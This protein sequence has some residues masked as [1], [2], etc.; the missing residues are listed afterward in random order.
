MEIQVDLECSGVSAEDVASRRSEAWDALS[1]IWS[2]KLDFTGWA[3]YPGKEGESEIEEVLS[4]A[5]KIR[6]TCDVFLVLGVGGSFMGAKAVIDLLG[7]RTSG[8]EVLFAGYNFSARYLREIFRKIEGKDL[9]LCVVSKSG[10]TTETLSAYGIFRE[11]MLEKYGA[12]EAAGRTYFVTEH[13][14]NYLFDLAEKEGSKVFDLAENIGGRYSVLTPVGL[15]PIA[16]S[17]IDIRNLMRGAEEIADP[18]CFKGN[19]LDYAI[20]RQKLREAGKGIEVFEFFDPYAAY[21]GEWLKQLFGESEGK[22]GKGIFP[23]SLMFSRDLHSMGQFLQQGAPEFFETFLL[24]GETGEPLRIPDSAKKPFAGKTMQQLNACAEK[25]VYD[26]HVAAGTPVIR[27]S[28]PEWN[29]ET[30][31]QLLY[32]FETECAVSA[33]LS[34]VNPFGQPGVEAYKKEMR[35]YIEKL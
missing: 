13:R 23:A 24:A 19:G 33:M 5:E 34:G 6:K 14:H 4:A 15:L 18:E 28:V 9:G 12:E 2:G 10:S 3:A 30:V 8:T 32:F 22:D 7:D 27:I 1:E 16:V 29:E 20:T 25:G 31:G 21:F 11:Y 17:G 26:A 35:G